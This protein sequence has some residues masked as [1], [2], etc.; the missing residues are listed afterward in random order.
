MARR[1]GSA[2]MASRAPR[3]ASEMARILDLFLPQFSYF[4]YSTPFAL[5]EILYCMLSKVKQSTGWA[6]SRVEEETHAC[7]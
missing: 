3:M 2:K 6:E 5:S 4:T 1:R 7:L